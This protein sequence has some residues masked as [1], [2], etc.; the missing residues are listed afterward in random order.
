MLAQLAFRPARGKI[1]HPGQQVGF[2]ADQPVSQDDD[3]AREHRRLRRAVRR[4]LRR[5]EDLPHHLQRRPPLP[6]PCV[7][8][9]AE[10]SQP[11]SREY[12]LRSPVEDAM[13]TPEQLRHREPGRV[14]VAAGVPQPGQRRLQPLVAG[15]VMLGP[16]AAAGRVPG[17]A[18]RG[19]QCLELRG[20]LPEVMQ[21]GPQ[22]DQAAARSTVTPNGCLRN[23]V[24]EIG[25]RVFA[26]RRRRGGDDCLGEGRGR[27]LCRRCRRHEGFKKE[28]D[29]LQV[30]ADR[31]RAVGTA[32]SHTGCWGPEGRN[33]PGRRRR[34]LSDRCPWER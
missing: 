3:R 33:S 7:I 21:R 34:R 16:L 26:F 25:D 31:R 29:L 5:A 1:S 20:Q 13:V 19:I 23:E 32:V 30:G 11:A 2:L 17:Q 15:Q 28:L 4:R 6:F 22:R 8:P 18:G 12:G 10:V 27:P 14:P 9:E 24:V